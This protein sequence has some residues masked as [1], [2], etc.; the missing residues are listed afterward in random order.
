MHWTTLEECHDQRLEVA[1]L[2]TGQLYRASVLQRDWSRALQIEVVTVTGVSLAFVP[3]PPTP[4][5]PRKRK[6][7]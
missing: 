1:D 7:P 4:K 5:T 3:A 2:P 6:T